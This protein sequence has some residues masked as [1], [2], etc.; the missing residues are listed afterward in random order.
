MAWFTYM[1]ISLP[2]SPRFSLHQ[3]YIPA[4][5]SLLSI[6]KTDITGLQLPEQEMY[7]GLG[8]KSVRMSALN[9]SFYHLPCTYGSCHFPKSRLI[10]RQVH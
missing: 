6:P 2:S 3:H 7:E 4:L 1:R 8:R 10:R 9:L 5:L